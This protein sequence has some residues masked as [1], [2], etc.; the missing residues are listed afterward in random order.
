M[1]RV[2]LKGG[3]MAGQRAES[4]ADRV[5]QIVLDI[6]A[7]EAAAG[8]LAREEL[9]GRVRRCGSELWLDTGDM[10]DA[11]SL[12]NHEFSAFTTNN[13]L[14]NKEV[15]KGTYDGLIERAAKILRGQVPEEELPLEIGFVLNARHAL[16]LVRRFGAMVSVELHT[17]LA[18]DVERS[19]AYGRRFHDIA[20][21]KF[22]VKVP[23]TPAGLL[24]AKKLEEQGISVNCTLGFSARQNH[25]IS[26]IAEPA[27]VNVFLGRLNSFVSDN[28]LGDGEM[29]GERAA[30]ASHRSVKQVRTDF[31]IQTRQ[32]AAS[33]RDGKQVLSLTGIDVLTMPVKVARQFEELSP[34]PERIV[35]N[36]AATPRIELAPGA[37]RKALGIDLLWDVS[38]SFKDAVR[39]LHD[40]DVEIMSPSDIEDF[41]SERGFPGFLPRWTEADRQAARDQGKIPRYEYWKSRIA[42]GLVDLDALMNLCAIH[43]F[44]SDQGKMDDRIRSML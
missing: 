41:F 4:V 43:S 19:V 36:A 38:D 32:I 11:A 2:D 28:G 7:E 22:Y 25:L 24:A 23:F 10:K 42:D 35:D 27:F 8:E 29:V 20:P 5:R 17:D 16:R 9:W 34:D 1:M 31:G 3:G 12:W 37:D 14:L 26:R 44:E 40:R 21:R 18:D 30:L 6:G 15:E 39:E 33:M 13:T